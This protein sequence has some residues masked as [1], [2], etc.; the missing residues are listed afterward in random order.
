[1][2]LFEEL[3]FE[4]TLKGKKS[5][6]NK[7]SRF[8]ESGGLEDFFEVNEEHIMY[9]DGYRTAPDEEESEIIFANDDYGIEVEEFDSEEFL[10]ILCKAA[11]NLDLYGYVSDAEGN[12]VRFS[13]AIG[14]TYYVDPLRAS[15]FNDELDEVALAEEEDE[16]EES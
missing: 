3:Y 7:F 10:E 6:L 2:T 14:D 15:S 16:D 11:K 1:M 13:S 12:E 4:I 8:L 9:G 5:E